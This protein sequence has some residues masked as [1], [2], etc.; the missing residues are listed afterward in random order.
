VQNDPAAASAWVATFPEGSLRDTASENLR[1][2]GPE[3][4]PLPAPGREASH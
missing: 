2:L 4:A 3:K 1:K